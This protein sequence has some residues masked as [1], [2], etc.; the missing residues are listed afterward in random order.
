MIE[1]RK[2]IEGTG[3]VDE[4]GKQFVNVLNKKAEKDYGEHQTQI[5]TVCY[6]ERRWTLIVHTYST[7]S[8]GLFVS[9]PE[10]EVLMVS[11]CGQ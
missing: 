8:A 10:H 9:S 7:S 1:K 4:L 6:R 11:Y 3:D 2:N 5:Q